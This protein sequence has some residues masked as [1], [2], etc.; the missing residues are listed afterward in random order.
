MVEIDISATNLIVDTALNDLCI[1]F[2]QMNSGEAS[3]GD[4]F[5]YQVL[6]NMRKY[7]REYQNNNRH[8]PAYRKYI[9]WFISEWPPKINKRG[10]YKLS[11]Y[12]PPPE[13]VLSLLD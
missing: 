3:T 8:K 10:D 12:I 2:I 6:S 1:K 13:I 5:W 11:Q 7:L 9:D 4:E